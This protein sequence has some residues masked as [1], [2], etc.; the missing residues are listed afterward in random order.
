VE[1][2]TYFLSAQSY[3][4]D[5]RGCIFSEYYVLGS[6]A[7]I[8]AKLFAGCDQDRVHRGS[9]F[10]NLRGLNLIIN[11]HFE[12]VGIVIEELHLIRP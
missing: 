8:K 3:H 9:F 1:Y 11:D 4:D 7:A 2:L 12:K 10:Q 6:R 5:S